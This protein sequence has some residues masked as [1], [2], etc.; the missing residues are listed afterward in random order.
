MPCTSAPNG[1]LIPTTARHRTARSQRSTS[2]ADGLATAADL[3][4]SGTGLLIPRL[5]GTQA[6]YRFCASDR[7]AV[8]LAQTLVEMNIADP[9]D[10]QQVDRD[11]IGYL[12]AT[13]NRWLDLHGARTIR[14][15]FCLTLMLSSVLD[16]YS[17]A[18]EADPDGRRL[19]LILDPTSAAYVVAKPTLELLEREHP[20][21]PAT[22]YRLFTGALNRWVRVYDYRDAEDRAE[23][24]REWIEGEEEEYEIADV[25]ASTPACMKQKPLNSGSLR[26]IVKH[27]AGSKARAIIEATLELRR[28]SKRAKGPPFTNDVREQLADSNPPLPSVLVVFSETD[29]IEAHF[30]DESQNMTEASPGPNLIIPLNAFDHSM[31]KIAFATVAVACKTLAAATRLI[32]LMPGN[33]KYQTDR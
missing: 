7:A 14:R 16:E 5:D 27:V 2:S 4:P 6:E 17:D 28:A 21:L 19:Y 32:D 31:V 22:F 30:D 29:A 12:K 10:W 11:P 23:M 24:L 1:T 15:R 8:Q 26:H 18:G 9:S 33:E 3:M 20:Q 25:A 13:L